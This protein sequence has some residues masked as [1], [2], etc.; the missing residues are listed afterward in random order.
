ML[1]SAFGQHLNHSQNRALQLTWETTELVISTSIITTDQTQI[2]RM[3]LC[4][5]CK[6]RNAPEG[7]A[8]ELGSKSHSTWESTSCIQT[9]RPSVSLQSLMSHLILYL[10]TTITPQLC[11]KSCVQ[12]RSIDAHNFKNNIAKITDMFSCCH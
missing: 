7:P 9:L 11:L 1:R 6:I 5:N 8:A 4:C 10:E 3:L 12:G 2:W